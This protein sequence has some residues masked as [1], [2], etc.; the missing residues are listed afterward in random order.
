MINVTPR[1]L[2]PLERPNT[3]CIGGGVSCRASL[4]GCGIFRPHRHS[5]PDIPARRE[6]LYQLN[7]LI[8]THKHTHE[9]TNKHTNITIREIS[10]FALFH[11]TYRLTQSM[12]TGLRKQFYAQQQMNVNSFSKAVPYSSDGHTYLVTAAPSVEFSHIS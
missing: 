9:N 8:Q 6:S 12:C 3:H 10:S 2:Y 4:D 11:P 1:P 5:N 7:Y